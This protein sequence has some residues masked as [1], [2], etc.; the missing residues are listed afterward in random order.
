MGRLVSVS[1]QSVE[2]WPVLSYALSCV[3]RERR[4]RA[5][6]P[7][8]ATSQRHG[9]ARRRACSQCRPRAPRRAAVVADDEQL[10]RELVLALVAVVGDDL[11]DLRV[12]LLGHVD[13][14]LARPPAREQVARRQ[15]V[16][17]AVNV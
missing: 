12:V 9:V 1:M 10:P 2:T 5:S 15:P 16:D 3:R 14:E 4:S 11:G 7:S 6:R 13:R 8:R 17:V